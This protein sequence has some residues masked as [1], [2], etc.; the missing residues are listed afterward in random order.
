MTQKQAKRASRHDYDVGY[1]R[2]PKHTQF[3]KGQSGNPKG[4]PKGAKNLRTI[5][6]SVLDKA[7]KVHEEG[8]PRSMSRLEA[9]CTSLYARALKGDNRAVEL[10]LRVR[11]RAELA[12]GSG[13]DGGK[14]IL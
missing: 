8:E 9:L 6:N 3:K 10:I 13:G 7:I 12:E 5:L 2:P 11:E 14:T 1:G 4:R